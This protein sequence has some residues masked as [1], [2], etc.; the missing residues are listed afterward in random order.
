MKIIILKGLPASGKTTWAKDFCEKNTDWVRVNRDDLRNMRGRYWLPKDEDMITE[1]EHNSV[2]SA[3]AY[4]K[5]VIL[6]STNLNPKYSKQFIDYVKSFQEHE[7]IEITG[8]YFD[9]T[10]EECIKRDKT[11]P[12]PV[13]ADV[14]RGMYE[15][16]IEVPIVYKEDPM[17]PHCIIVD[18]DGTLALNTGGRSPYDWKRVGEDTLNSPVNSIVTGYGDSGAGSIFLMSGRDE[19]CRVETIEWLEREGVYYE[20]LFMR[21]AG[22][23]EKDAII[24]KR[25]FEE[26]IRGKYYVD[27]VL[28][29]RDQVVRMWRKE[30]GLTCLQINYGSF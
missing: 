7:N 4:G 17:L 28:D 10:P 14:I 16:Y 3:L 5:N 18:I 26:N 22:N 19:S 30:L 29:D 13:G 20:Q 27:Y 23:A 2:M 15:K 21:P 8:K 11:R 24:K 9:V 6:D 1:W 25:L 12:N